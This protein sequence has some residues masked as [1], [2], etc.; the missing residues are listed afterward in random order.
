MDYS[1]IR[2][3]KDEPPM[4]ILE[5]GSDEPLFN[6]HYMPSAFLIASFDGDYLTTVGGHTFCTEQTAR[7]VDKRSEW[8]ELIDKM[9]AD[10][11]KHRRDV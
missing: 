11:K 2:Y 9:V 1:E 10:I 7:E 8:Q 6:L 5:D 3:G 4:V